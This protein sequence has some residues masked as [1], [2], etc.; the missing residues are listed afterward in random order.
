MLFKNSIKLSENCW[1]HKQNAEAKKKYYKKDIDVIESQ[2]EIL[3]S[4]S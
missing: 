4:K 2:E 3:M 1:Q